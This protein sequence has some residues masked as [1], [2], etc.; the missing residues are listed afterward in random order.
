MKY[1]TTSHPVTSHAGLCEIGARQRHHQANQATAGSNVMNLWG[2]IRW[3]PVSMRW[4]DVSDTHILK[5]KKVL[6][7]I[8]DLFWC[9]FMYMLSSVGGVD[10]QARLVHSS[11][12]ALRQSCSIQT[13]PSRLA[14]VKQI[15]RF[16]SPSPTAISPCALF[17][18][19][20]LSPRCFFSCLFCSISLVIFL[21]QPFILALY[22]SHSPPFSLLFAVIFS[23]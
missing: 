22:L 5:K 7:F 1:Y 2:K 17:P 21:S 18:I 8:V 20:L 16:Y 15:T 9:L 11:G 19:H 4:N 13:T 23:H 14:S 6:T 10:Q 3:D 12:S